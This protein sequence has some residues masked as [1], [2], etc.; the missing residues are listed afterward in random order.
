MYLRAMALRDPGKLRPVLKALKEQ[1]W[2]WAR[3]AKSHWRFVS[4]AGDIVFAAGTPR[5]PE[6][7]HSFLADLRRAGF[8]RP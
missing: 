4:P 5:S 3:T 1:G 8:K 6:S 2:K 7:F